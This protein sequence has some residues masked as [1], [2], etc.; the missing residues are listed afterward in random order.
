MLVAV[1]IDAVRADVLRNPAGFASCDARLANRV[2]QRGLAVID[3]PHES[4]DRRARLEFLFLLNHRR[5]RRD[6]R[7]FHLVNAAAFFAPLLFENEPVAFRNLRRDIGL[8]CLV[9]V[10]ENLC[11]HQLRD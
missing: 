10:G 1:V 8:D 4:D 5:R 7:L 6:H 11:V 9:D 3:V 2:H